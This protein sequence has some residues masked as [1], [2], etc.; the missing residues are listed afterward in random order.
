MGGGNGYVIGAD[1]PDEALDFL[2]FFLQPEYNIELI[3]VENIIPVVDGAESALEDK[4]SLKIID[5]V[6]NADY[7][8][9][10]YDQFLPPAVGEAVKDAVV[11]LLAGQA[12]PEET[13]QMVQ[14]S[15]EAEQ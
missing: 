8:Q 6:A 10:Y 15:W 9:L 12:T 14:D 3:G 5:A 7:Y 1:A 2:S 4:N 13:A 11:A